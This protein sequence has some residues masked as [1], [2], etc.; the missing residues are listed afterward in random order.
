MTLFSPTASETI[1]GFFAGVEL[2]PAIL[3]AGVFT[4]DGLLKGK[5][6]VSTKNE[7][8]PAAVME[9]LARCVRYAVDECDLRMSDIA[10]VGVA[11]PGQINS[12]GILI[13]SSALGW[14]R[15]NV[16]GMLATLLGRPVF[17]GQ[18][19]E[20]GAAGIVA[21]E[22]AH[23]RASRVLALFPGPQVGAATLVD[24]RPLPL[25]DWCDGD[26]VHTSLL[27]NVVDTVAHPVFGNFRGRDFRKA[28]KKDPGGQMRA[29]VL[30]LA[31]RAGV[32]AARL[33]VRFAPELIVLGGA[34][35]DEMSE[36]LLNEARSAYKA[37]GGLNVVETNWEVS[38]LGDLAAIT[39]AS[40]LAQL[41]AV[42]SRI[43]AADA[44][45]AEGPLPV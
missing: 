29:Y 39:G 1:G 41:R 23:L 21:R 33:S 45:L 7:R 37:A 28:L 26:G 35:V 31:A 34:V 24:G 36:E 25:R 12:D 3:R 17:A 43:R 9:R 20:L 27:E 32:A 10:A 40:C 19:H 8:G 14:G 42:A 44:S 15:E 38:G 13:K 4:P 22:F 11:M 18:L 16:A 30:Q 5:G 2:G 6:K